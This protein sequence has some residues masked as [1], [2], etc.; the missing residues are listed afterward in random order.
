M[1]TSKGD[2]TTATYCERPKVHIDGNT[3]ETDPE[4]AERKVREVNK[5]QHVSEATKRFWQGCFEGIHGEMVW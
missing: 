4:Y 5:L 1:T 3:F 2:G